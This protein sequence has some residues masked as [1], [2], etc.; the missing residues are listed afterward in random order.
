MTP[1]QQF[2][3]NLLKDIPDQQL[4]RMQTVE[5]SGGTVILMTDSANGGQ[6]FFTIEQRDFELALRAAKSGC[7]A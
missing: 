7:Q 1:A 2:V 3:S 4:L 5:S 6:Y